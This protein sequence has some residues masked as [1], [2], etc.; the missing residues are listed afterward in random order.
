MKYILKDSF[1]NTKHISEIKIRGGILF[2]EILN[3]K[4]F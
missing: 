3:F 4:N 1:I 2:A